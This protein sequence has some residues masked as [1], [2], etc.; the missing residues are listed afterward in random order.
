MGVEPWPSGYGK[1]LMFQRLWV[2]ILA[3]YTGWT[4]FTYICC[5]NCNDVCLKRPKISKKRP[6]FKKRNLKIKTVT[7]ITTSRYKQILSFGRFIF[8]LVAN[9]INCYVLLTD[10]IAN[11]A[12]LIYYCGVF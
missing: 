6:V 4:F 11:C 2:R 9:I 8:S 3:L 7:L 5:K 1:R 10:Y 12:K